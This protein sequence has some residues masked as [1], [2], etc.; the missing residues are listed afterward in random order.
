M[1]DSDYYKYAKED[2]DYAIKHPYTLKQ[3]QQM[4]VAMGYKYYYRADKLCVRREQR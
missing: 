4:L 2:I 3:F 1:R